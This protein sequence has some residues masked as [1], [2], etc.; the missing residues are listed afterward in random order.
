MPL[1]LSLLLL[2]TT[3]GDGFFEHEGA[4]VRASVCLCLSF[5]FK[6]KEGRGFCLSLLLVL[7]LVL[8]LCFFIFFFPLLISFEFGS[9]LGGETE[10]ALLSV[11]LSVGD[12]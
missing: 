4:C 7:V 8:V 6:G 12:K 1:S 3:V 10:G 9:N 2:A 11:C 5:L